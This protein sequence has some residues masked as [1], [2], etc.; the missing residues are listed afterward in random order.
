MA[1]RPL[2]LGHRGRRTPGRRTPSPRSRKAR[3]LGA[4]GVELDARRTADGV[5]VV[6]HDP[7][8]DGFGLIVEHPF[9]A[10][11]AAHPE[12]PTLAEALDACAGMIVNVEI[13]CLPWEPDA[14]TPD[15]A[16]V[17]AVVEL[18]RAQAAVPATD[19]HRVVVRPRFDRRVPRARAGD[20]DRL[21]D[22]RPGR[23]ASARRSRPSTV[24]RG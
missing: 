3:E 11:R 6:H 5:L 1:H 23:F 4:D 16:V 8:V 7:H 14:D 21:V 18:L 15:R 13:K 12:I 2:V 19:R 17:H 24:T 10:L 22:E 9:A 20:R